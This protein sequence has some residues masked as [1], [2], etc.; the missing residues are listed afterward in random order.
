[1]SGVDL[2]DM[3]LELYRTDIP[4]QKCYYLLPYSFFIASILR[5]VAVGLF[6]GKFSYCIH[7]IGKVKINL[8]K[9]CYSNNS[10]FGI[11]NMNHD[12]KDLVKICTNKSVFHWKRFY[13]AFACALSYSFKTFTRIHTQK[14]IGASIVRGRQVYF[15][16]DH[17]SLTKIIHALGNSRIA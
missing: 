9:A 1:M 13:N 11:G 8:C 7:E 3:L 16:V 15:W 4:M 10:Y 17:Y 2:C 5:S 6:S 12:N 14:K